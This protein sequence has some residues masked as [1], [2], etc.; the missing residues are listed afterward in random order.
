MEKAKKQN[1]FINFINF[2]QAFRIS[3]EDAS[4]G[5]VTDEDLTPKER[6]FVN[7]LRKMT[8]KSLKDVDPEKADRLD[9]RLKEQAAN[10]NAANNKPSTSTDTTPPK[11]FKPT[12]TIRLEDV[13]DDDKFFDDFFED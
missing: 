4:N 10:N 2:I 9:K 1:L 7:D 12:P 3:E 11:M 8:G 6:Q 5:R 13:S